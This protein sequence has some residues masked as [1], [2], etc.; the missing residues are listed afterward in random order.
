MDN[1]I[2]Y[3]PEERDIV[4]WGVVKD[5]F[6][7][8]WSLH[9][10]PSVPIKIHENNKTTNLSGYVQPLSKQLEKP[11][12]D[13]WYFSPIKDKYGN[14]WLANASRL[15]HYDYKNYELII[16]DTSAFY[17]AEDRP[18]NPIISGVGGGVNIIENKPPY[19]VTRLREKDGL[20]QNQQMLC[21]FVDSKG[22]HW[23]GCGGGLTRY[24]YDKKCLKIFLECWEFTFWNSL[25]YLR[26]Q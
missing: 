17:V 24:D 12:L 25:L 4:S 19:K 11:I 1:G 23:Y 9:Y 2:K 21:V 20:L 16:N 14:L 13:N 22:T 8:L 26:R 6:N 7:R 18:R 5:K 15:V 3:I 10:N